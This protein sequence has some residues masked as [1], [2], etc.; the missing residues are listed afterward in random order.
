MHTSARNLG[1][2]FSDTDARARGPPHDAPDPPRGSP[3]RAPTLSCQV[4]YIHNFDLLR[5]YF[6][7]LS[8]KGSIVFSNITLK[9]NLLHNT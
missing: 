1:P 6:R 7:T 4:T 2:K 8:A 5:W 3:P 9:A